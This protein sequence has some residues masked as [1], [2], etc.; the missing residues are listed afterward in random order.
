[1]E[2]KLVENDQISLKK[3]KK[4]GRGVEKS[5]NKIREAQIFCLQMADI[6][7]KCEEKRNNMKN[8]HF[9]E[10]TVAKS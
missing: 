6:C 7:E 4:Q 2:G 3:A 10:I 8:L 9:F 5:R 1:M